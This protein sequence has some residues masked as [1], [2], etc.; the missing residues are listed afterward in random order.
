[1]C[2]NVVCSSLVK[3]A[4]FFFNSSMQFKE[5][6]VVCLSLREQSDQ[7]DMLTVAKEPLRLED[8][9]LFKIAPAALEHVVSGILWSIWA[10][11]VKAKPPFFPPSLPVLLPLVV[12]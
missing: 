5:A 9:L 6:F 2:I 7:S 3:Q 12:C 4:G 1:M 8:E 11:F 10:P